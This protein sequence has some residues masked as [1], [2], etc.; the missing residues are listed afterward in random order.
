VDQESEEDARSARWSWPVGVW[1]VATALAVILQIGGYFWWAPEH[2]GWIA[3][4][5]TL[6]IVAPLL[7]AVV[8]VGLHATTNPWIRRDSILWR[9]LK[10]VGAAFG[11]L[12]GL[13]LGALL[14]AIVGASVATSETVSDLVPS[15]QMVVAIIA[16]GVFAAVA[17]W[18]L[19]VA[20]DMH[21]LGV[22]RR[23]KAARRARLLARRSDPKKA[24]RRVAELADP[25][26]VGLCGVLTLMLIA[27]LWVWV[28]STLGTF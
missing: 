10:G 21:R 15:L 4:W 1:V 14:G 13:G 8:V 20:V 28:S 23:A 6:P 7:A 9:W 17:W 18:S 27:Q 11:A 22:K 26:A 19:V 3:V 24:A 5:T 16:G 25:F 2:R 12:V